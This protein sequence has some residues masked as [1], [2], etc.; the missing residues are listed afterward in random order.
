MSEVDDG[1]L[2]CLCVCMFIWVSLCTQARGGHLS[3]YLVLR[4]GTSCVH[5]G[6]YSKPDD[7]LAFRHFPVSLPS[8]CWSAGITDAGFCI[9]I[10]LL[11]LF[12]V[13]VPSIPRKYFHRG[14]YLTRI[15]GRFKDEE[16]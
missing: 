6:V 11:L 14:I 4:Q 3:F 7:M 8:H 16:R 9:W 2:S 5:Q 1:F 15:E 13:W 12:G 10:I